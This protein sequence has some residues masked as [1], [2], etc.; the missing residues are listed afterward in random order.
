MRADLWAVAEGLE[1]VAI[2][3]VPG[4]DEQ[5]HRHSATPDTARAPGLIGARVQAP[6]SPGPVGGQIRRHAMEGWSGR[7]LFRRVLQHLEAAGLV[8]ARGLHLGIG[9]RNRGAAYHHAGPEPV[10][11]LGG[12]ADGD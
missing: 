4:I 3:G 12:L 6:V 8:V 1:T 10:L 9:H 2:G 11:L 7:G 5:L